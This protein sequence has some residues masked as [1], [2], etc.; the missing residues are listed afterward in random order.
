M[1]A[2]ATFRLQRNAWNGAVEPRLVLHSA[3]PAAPPPVEVLGEPASFGA[4]WLAELDAPLEPWPPPAPQARR[5]IVDARG[6][7]IAGTVA[8]V[9][10][11]GA[12]VLVVCVDVPR[13]LR[14]LAGRLGGFAL[15]SYTALERDPAQAEPFAH[16]IAL[17][18]PAHAH[19]AALLAAGA[20]WT[21]LAWGEPELRFAQQIIEQEYGLRAPL[22]T[23]YRGLRDLGGADG[24]ELEAALRGDAPQPRSPGLAG[25]LMRVLRELHLV[26]LDSDRLAVTVPASERTALER[27]A[28]FRHYEQRRQDGQRYLSRPTARAA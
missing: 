13:R 11:S 26:S 12:P 23:L 27:S 8:G 25:R 7:G 20:G 9:V 21:H 6:R 15:C 19:Q 4:G 16:V 17:D 24:E 18:P 22:A 28:A 3:R 10:A 14:G 1:P 5:E 2:D